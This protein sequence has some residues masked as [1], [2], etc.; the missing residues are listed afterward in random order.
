MGEPPS[1]T[2]P[3]CAYAASW[4]IVGALPACSLVSVAINDDQGAYARAN[5]IYEEA[6]ALCRQLGDQWMIAVVLNNL[7]SV[8]MQQGDW[9]GAEVLLQETLAI[10]RA[11]GDQ[12]GAA[13]A[14]G[15]LAEVALGRQDWT[16]ARALVKESLALFQRANSRGG[17]AACF[18]HMASVEHAQGHAERAARLLAM[19][20]QL[21]E[22][23]HARMTPDEQAGFEEI[24]GQVRAQLNERALAVLW[25]EGRALPLADAIA[26]VLTEPPTILPNS[27]EL[28]ITAL[29]A[30]S[31]Q[32][33]GIPLADTDWKYA[34]ARELFFF[35][36]TRARAT[37]EQLGLALI[38]RCI[39]SPLRGAAASCT[40][41]CAQGAPAGRLDFVRERRV[42][43]QPR[44]IILV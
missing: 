31:V 24:I 5:A 17:I 33:N 27:V 39:V 41:S 1:Y 2:R 32:R 43:N 37:K 13:I 38:S 26:Y 23:I 16:H 3:V 6:L 21:R 7:G 20:E 29:G 18:V 10:R 44:P 40:A 11:L 15:N 9:N 34:K 8:A 25:A 42:F 28:Y 30:T 4:E 22:M 35:L 12:R 14:L 19:S 36:L